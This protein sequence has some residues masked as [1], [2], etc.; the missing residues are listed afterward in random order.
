MGE[1]AIGQGLS[2]FEDPKLVQGQGYFIDDVVYPGM[3]FGVVLRSPHA[4]AKIASIDT[5]AAKAAPGVLAV[6]TAADIKVA[7][8]GDLPGNPGLKRRGGVAMHSPR[9]PVLADGYVR[10]VGDCVAFIVAET[11][12]QA[13]DALELINVDY[14]SLT[15]VTSTEAAAKPGAP[16]V[17]DQFEDN[18]AFVQ[19]IGDKAATDAAFANAAHVVKHR[20]VIN[21][22]TAACMEPRGA[23]GHY[24]PG[25]G[26][27]TIHSPLQRAH[28]YRQGLAKVLNVPESKLHVTTGDVGGSFGMKTPVFNEAPLVLLA[29]PR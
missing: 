22:I 27:Y 10:W 28:T 1:F 17:H 2:R 4:Y 7:G 21:R 24:N 29:A 13:Q 3:A 19:L 18:I 25:N 9:Y 14:E 20:F 15:A 26:R 12:A 16:R 11:A 8:I 23:V 5:E 6:L